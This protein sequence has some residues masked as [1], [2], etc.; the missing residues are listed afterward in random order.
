MDKR[1]LLLIEALAGTTKDLLRLVKPLTEASARLH[2][3]NEW[4]V[5]T[6]IA[7]LIYIEPL[8]R[9]RLKRIVEIDNPHEPFIN[10]NEA[11]HLTAS[12]HHSITALIDLFKSQRAITTAFLAGLTQP[13]WLRVC[14][15]DEFG[16]TRL[17]KQVEIL[18]GH[19]NEHLAQI[20][21]V[22]E[23]L[24]KHK[25]MQTPAVPVIDVGPFL[26]G[27]ANDKHRIAQAIGRACK[28]IGF[29]IIVGHGVPNDLLTRMADVSRRFFD[30]PL[31]DK[32]RVPVNPSG[33]GYVPMKQEALAASLGEKTPG[34]LKES[35]NIGRHFDQYT[36][37]ENPT[38][39]RATW[40]EYFTTL[41][42]LGANIM[43]M[44]ALALNLPEHY[45]DDKIDPPMAFL[46][47]INY[48]EP[49]EAPLPGQLRAGA[50]SDYGTLTILLSENKPGGL[51]VRNRAGQW[52]DVVAPP[53]SFVVNIGDMMQMWT[54]DKWLSTVHRVVNPPADKAHERGAGSRR[55]SLVFFHTP[56]ENTRIE[57][58]AS[59]TSA[60]NPP[61]H[62]PILASEHMRQKSDKAGTLAK[63]TKD[64]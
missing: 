26:N 20:V 3:T 55:Q 21:S 30:L 14:T 25:A 47:A 40:I 44:F 27:G 11:E 45:F 8:F 51:Q 41:N 23:W 60:D 61:R 7:H 15:H 52:L 32:M 42:A 36:W 39:L 28:D 6:I 29:L 12:Q 53:A 57:C 56:N 22:R 50:H 17:R 16:V 10:P 9:A 37:P 33:V 1:Y 24:D 63:A 49:T 18:V 35:Y 38:D 46:R 54:N 64:T 19:D 58:L 2:P 59:C 31:S 4:S 5:A 34:D 13:Q 43:R 48:P 62:A